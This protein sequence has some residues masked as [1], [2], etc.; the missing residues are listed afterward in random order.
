MGRRS[1]TFGRHIRAAVK[2]LAVLE[3]KSELLVRE[4]LGELIGRAAA[5]VVHREEG[6]LP[7]SPHEVEIFAEVGVIRALLGPIWLARM[8]EAA[9]YHDARGIQE[10]YYPTTPSDVRPPRSSDNLP[11]PSYPYFISYGET[12]DQVLE[13]LGR[14]TPLV[15]IVGLGGTGKSSLALEAAV[16]TTRRTRRGAATSG[17][18]F[19]SA[20]WI[21]DRDQPGTTRLGH[22][23]DEIARTLGH[24]GYTALEPRVKKAEVEQL[25]RLQRVL[26]VVDN[27][28][29]I[30]DPELLAWLL[31]LPEPSKAL[32]TTRSYHPEFRKGA[33]LIELDG[34]DEQAVGE[35]ITQ[36]AGQLKLTLTHPQPAEVDRQL[37]AA[38][39]GNPG[40]IKLILGLV[41][42]GFPKKRSLADIL[43]TLNDS[44]NEL[45]ADLYAQ[46]WRALGPDGQLTLMALGVFPSSCTPA[47]LAVLTELS[48]DRQE[49][50]LARLHDL[51]LLDAVLDG[52]AIPTGMRLRVHPLTRAFAN[53]R[54]AEAPELDM[55]LHQRWL[56]WCSAFAA[57]HGGFTLNDIGRLSTLDAE[58]STLY[59][60]VNY[61]ITQGRHREDRKSVV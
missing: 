3:G 58:E 57:T 39:G 22:V 42:Y 32:A 14:R 33:W 4:Q 40:A 17:P 38:T 43:Q 48:S 23:L 46:S 59:A 56:D 36:I 16:H 55:A 37:F 8:V 41:K 27:V 51:A 13:G 52:E 61:A 29:T 1:E 9:R 12:F 5:A 53:A 34:M 2:A 6:Q 31:R 45:F 47:S 20:V 50:A 25:L 21:S 54:L 19:D 44:H 18:I 60:A 7:T 28:E 24:H 30:S 49:L 26:I 15:V 10:K 11:T 35:L